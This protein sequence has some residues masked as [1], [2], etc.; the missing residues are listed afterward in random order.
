MGPDKC[1]IKKGVELR[2]VRLVV[3]A[4]EQLIRQNGDASEIE[5][6]VEYLDRADHTKLNLDIKML[7]RESRDDLARRLEGMSVEVELLHLYEYGNKNIIV[8]VQLRQSFVDA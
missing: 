8:D 5:V 7:L 2:F 3:D 6:H 4:A 1:P